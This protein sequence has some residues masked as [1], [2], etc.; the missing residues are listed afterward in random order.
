MV[1]CCIH[2]WWFVYNLLWHADTFEPDCTYMYA[3]HLSCKSSTSPITSVPEASASSEHS[4]TPLFFSSASS[5]S[6]EKILLAEDRSSMTVELL[7]LVHLKPPRHSELLVDLNSSLF[8]RLMSSLSRGCPLAW[9]SSSSL[10][11][12]GNA[13][14]LC[15]AEICKLWFTGKKVLL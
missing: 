2:L 12:T 14:T 8:R 4:L 11:L 6:R 15:G 13:L 10:R 9:P 3:S 5:S 7:V 1:W